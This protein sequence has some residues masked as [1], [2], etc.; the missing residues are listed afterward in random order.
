MAAALTAAVAAADVKA[1][2]PEE[3]HWVYAELKEYKQ[4]I[5]PLRDEALASGP[6][7]QKEWSEFQTDVLDGG[8]LDAP[9]APDR[10]AT[11]LKLSVRMPKDRVDE[12][13]ATYVYGLLTA[14]DAAAIAREDAVGGLVK[15]L[16][17]ETISGEWQSEGEV[18]ASRQL[19][20]FRDIDDKQTGL[21]SIAYR[22][23]ILDATVT[24]GK[25]FRPKAKL[26]HAE[27]I[28]MMDR[29]VKTYAGVTRSVSWPSSHW[30]AGEMTAFLNSYGAASNIALKALLQ[31][32]APA[33]A[34]ELDK[35]VP[36]KLWHELLIA[37]LKLP[38]DS[39][40]P[41]G[42]ISYEDYTIKLAGGAYIARDRA[43]AGAV[44]LGGPLRDA[45]PKER[46]EARKAFADYDEAFDDSKLALAVHEALV[47]GYADGT[48]KPRSEL[49][50]GE[51]FVLAARLSA[52]G[53]RS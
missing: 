15:L 51:A 42:R 44:K 19:A 11:M 36:V 31:R 16:T 32:N 48:F 13:L 46:E 34:A 9:I 38:A 20:D 29:V 25:A 18:D 24:N 1:P 14:P 4:L 40:L 3:K 47:G 27:A 37:A 12:L 7:T 6:L 22:D 26:T 5:A 35:P 53:T 41:N 8:K 49:T 39:K 17:I 52:R 10:W 43:I 28:S 21:V 50:Y 45:T 30:S 2:P 33:Q 23:G